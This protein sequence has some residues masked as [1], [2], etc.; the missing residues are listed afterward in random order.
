MWITQSSEHGKSLFL[1]FGAKILLAESHLAWTAGGARHVLGPD[2]FRQRRRRPSAGG[3]GRAPA[4]RAE[5]RRRRQ[6]H[7]LSIDSLAAVL[8]LSLPS[9]QLAFPSLSLRSRQ[10]AQ[11]AMRAVAPPP[12]PSHGSPSWENLPSACALAGYGPS[13]CP[14][15]HGECYSH[16]TQ[17]KGAGNEW[18]QDYQNRK[19]RRHLEDE[20]PWSVRKL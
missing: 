20:I 9:R 2:Q 7:S 12:L 17:G 5:R 19:R 15:S 13:P 14:Y 10:L 8:F 3:V 18:F 16:G 6:D 1:W 11:L 4:E